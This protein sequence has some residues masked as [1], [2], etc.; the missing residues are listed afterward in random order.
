MARGRRH[1][2]WMVRK[3]WRFGRWR[4]EQDVEGGL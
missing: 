2:R 1:G 3:V 4:V